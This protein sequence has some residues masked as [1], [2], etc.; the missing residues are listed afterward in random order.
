MKRILCFGA[1]VNSTAI[2]VLHKQ[3]QFDRI[4][5]ADTGCEHPDTYA[6]IQNYVQPYAKECGFPFDVVRF[7]DLYQYYYERH[8]IPT[9]LF[10][11]CTDKFKI[12]P[13]NEF[14][15][16]FGE[17]QL[18]M[19]IDAGEVHRAKNWVDYDYPLIRLGLDRLKCMRTIEAAKFP[20][21]RKSG[22]YICP[23]T[24]QTGW[25]ILL[26]EYPDLFLAAENLEKNN[27]RYPELILSSR[28][29]EEIRIKRGFQTMLTNYP[30][31]RCMMCE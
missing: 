14:C 12:R 2:L 15:K 26:H 5:F 23:F 29:L 18:V 9:R 19:G 24:P 28:P 30:E 10:R 3:I 16:Q 17:Y 4:V 27:R 13:I 8:I 22:C 7:G 21:P 11:H 25:F 31:T 1:G 20:V 6:F